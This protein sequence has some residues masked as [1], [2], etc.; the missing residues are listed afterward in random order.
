MHACACV[1]LLLL[2]LNCVVI[3]SYYVGHK[4]KFG[5]E[6]LEFEFSP[7]GES[8]RCLCFFFFY[9]WGWGRQHVCISPA[10]HTRLDRHP[11]LFFMLK[12]Y[13]HTENTGKLRYANNSEYK[14]DTMIRKEVGGCGGGVFEWVCECV[15]V[16][17]FVSMSVCLCVHGPLFQR[18]NWLL[19]IAMQCFVSPAVLE[20]LKRIIEDSEVSA[21]DM[22]THVDG[23]GNF[24]SV[25]FQFALPI[26]FGLVWF[27]S[28]N[29]LMA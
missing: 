10:K 5:H 8:P 25:P 14:N 3:C 15:Y 4:G 1:S 24:F 18:P 22:H 7:D 26:W 11:F 21:V 12:H 13:P 28:P 19:A 27:G 29:S 23:K 9:L 17:V 20:E 16:S 6:F 2:L